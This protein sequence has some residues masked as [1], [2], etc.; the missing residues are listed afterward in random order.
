MR[1]PVVYPGLPRSAVS[2][3]GSSLS[4]NFCP[5]HPLATEHI[6]SYRPLTFSS[7]FSLVYLWVYYPPPPSLYISSPSLLEYS[8]NMYF[9]WAFIL[10]LADDSKTQTWA[11]RCV[12]S[13]SWLY[14]PPT[15]LHPFCAGPWPYASQTIVYY[16]TNCEPRT[17]KFKFHTENLFIRI[18]SNTT[19]KKK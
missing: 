5:L 18:K 9:I 8:N 13:T 12:P 19:I 11:C 17:G 16:L 1:T 2:H 6:L 7:M 15:H 10:K 14:A 3:H 4:I